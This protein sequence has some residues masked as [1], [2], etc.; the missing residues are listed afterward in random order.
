VKACDEVHLYPPELLSL[1][2]I[3]KFEENV[4]DL[5]QGRQL[6][7]HGLPRDSFIRSFVTERFP[8]ARIV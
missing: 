6:V 8:D 4:A 5:L 7:I 2:D 1:S 3:H